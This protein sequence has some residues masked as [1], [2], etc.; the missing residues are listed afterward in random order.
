MSDSEHWSDW[1]GEDGTVYKS[2]FE[3][4]SFDTVQDCLVYDKKAYGVNLESLRVR[5]G[6]DYYGTMKLVNYIRGHEKN[7]GELKDALLNRDE[8]GHPWQ[9][10]SFFV[11]VLSNDGLLF[12]ID[13]EDPDHVSTREGVRAEAEV[14]SMLDQKPAVEPK[15]CVDA[16]YFSSYSYL[17]IHRT[18]LEDRI[19][20]L[21]YKDAIERAS[22]SGK[23]V[24]DVGCGTGILSM[25]CAGAGASQVIGVDNAELVPKTRRV[26][27]SNGYSD[28]ITVLKST[29]E[30]LRMDAIPEVDA[31][32]SEWMGYFCIYESMLQSVIYARE[33][34]LKPGGT[35]LP[36]RC[37]MNIAA[38]TQQ[39]YDDIAFW[40]TKLYGLDFSSLVE[41]SSEREALVSIVDPKQL[42]SD[43]ATFYALD[44][45][46]VQENDLDF[47]SSFC[48]TIAQS[49]T[50]RSLVIAFDTFFE[51]Q[52]VTLSTSG[53]APPTHWKQTV[54]P[55]QRGIECQSGEEIKGT[56][57]ASRRAVNKRSYTIRL[58]LG[59][60]SQEYMLR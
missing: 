54:L 59:G 40:N 39:F 47:T 19:R 9:D 1:E 27:A 32:V 42:C 13:M 44:M 11:P 28:R 14:L 45:Y 25:F 23:T 38:S 60:V 35:M 53:S 57:H 49:C 21:A 30:D 34:W 3:D 37:T 43:E 20:T 50:V 5:F 33:N 16:E 7:G 4:K 6:L 56:L 12:S 15:E 52:K 17:D 8:R 51:D 55:L 41:S 31:I 26:I 46:T 36:S 24:L 2:L 58:D 48:L 10:E 22:L 18:M 29:L